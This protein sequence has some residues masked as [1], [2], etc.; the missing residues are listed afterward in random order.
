M[1]WTVDLAMLNPRDECG[2]ARVAWAKV[3]PADGLLAKD[4]TPL[5]RL[6]YARMATSEFVYEMARFRADRHAAGV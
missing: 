5:Q 3:A 1:E 4:A 6:L 2:Q